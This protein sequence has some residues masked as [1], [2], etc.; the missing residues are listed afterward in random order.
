MG[1]TVACVESRARR[2]FTHPVEALDD[3]LNAAGRELVNDGVERCLFSKK[4]RQDLKDLWT[5]VLVASLHVIKDLGCHKG[6]EILGQIRRGTEDDLR[7][8]MGND[9]RL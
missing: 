5:V 8:A 4:L 1:V 9:G 7:K 3:K 2:R 6:E